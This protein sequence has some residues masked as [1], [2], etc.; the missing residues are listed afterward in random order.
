MVRVDFLQESLEDF[1]RQAENLQHLETKSRQRRRSFY[2]LFQQQQTH[3]AALAT[4]AGQEH[5]VSLRWLPRISE[6][7]ME[8]IVI[9]LT[10]D[11]IEQRLAD[12][13]EEMQVSYQSLR[14]QADEQKQRKMKVEKVR[15]SAKAAK[16]KTESGSKRSLASGEGEAAGEAAMEEGGSSS[17]TEAETEEADATAGED[18]EDADDFYQGLID[19]ETRTTLLRLMEG[20]GSA[21]TGNVLLP[22]NRDSVGDGEGLR[23]NMLFY[24]DEPH[25]SSALHRGSTNGA[26][27]HGHSQHTTQHTAG[28]AGHTSASKNLSEPIPVALLADLA[29]LKH[30]NESLARD[31]LDDILP[32]I[33]QPNETGLAARML[34]EHYMLLVK[35]HLDREENR[36]DRDHH[37]HKYETELAAKE[38]AM[39]KFSR[40]ELEQQNVFQTEIVDALEK[41]YQEKDRSD[42]ELASLM[43]LLK[44]T[45][46]DLRLVVEDSVEGLVKKNY[47]VES[48][49]VSMYKN[50]AELLESD[51]TKH[52]KDAHENMRQQ[53][54]KIQKHS[55]RLRAFAERMNADKEELAEEVKAEMRASLVRNREDFVDSLHEHG[56]G[57][58]RI[59]EEMRRSLTV[60]KDE[61]RASLA[62][63]HDAL[64]DR[65]SARSGSGSVRM[66]NN[67][68]SDLME[69]FDRLEDALEEVLERGGQH[70]PLAT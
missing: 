43:E 21:T 23:K 39:E 54:D 61:V 13:L 52:L 3:K 25:E 29:L 48:F 24:R 37:K 41:L 35:I 62:G 55:D 15:E 26:S 17:P 8:E 53:T 44:Q 66:D 22:W 28:G 18:E 27:L 49:Q 64:L 45:E 67:D 65:L 60:H 10:L 16:R 46:G 11:G 33:K 47:E 50:R 14:M 12:T 4:V 30:A 19:D 7:H 20:S 40:D 38:A 2:A 42:R 58:D 31:V 34:M 68:F 57:M 9:T 69:R 6:E 70:F 36:E 63:H 1:R 56:K 59:E 32:V 51:V 5:T